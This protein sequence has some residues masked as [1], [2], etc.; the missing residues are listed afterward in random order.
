MPIFRIF[1]LMEM[2][3]F[4]QMFVEPGLFA[5]ERGTLKTKIDTLLTETI[6]DMATFE[7]GMPVRGQPLHLASE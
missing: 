7:Q 1:S 4:L 3:R 2:K 5:G 6:P